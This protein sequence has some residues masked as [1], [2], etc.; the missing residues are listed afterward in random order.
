[1]NR[2][3]RTNEAIAQDLESI[4]VGISGDAPLLK[5]AAAALRGEVYTGPTEVAFSR[6]EGPRWNV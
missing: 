4:K 5:E 6:N 2:R 3:P 1:M